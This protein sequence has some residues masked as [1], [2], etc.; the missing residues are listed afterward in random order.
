MSYEEMGD[1]LEILDLYA[2]YVHAVDRTDYDTLENR[3]FISETS[4][5][6][7]TLAARSCPGHR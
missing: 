6:M 5:D 7:T 1:R 3:I 4:F 2:R